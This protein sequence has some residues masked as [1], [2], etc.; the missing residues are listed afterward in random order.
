MVEI[1][2]ENAYSDGHESARTTKVAEPASLSELD[3]EDWWQD[4]VFPQTGDG[5]GRRRGRSGGAYHQVTVI[6]ADTTALIGQTHE[7]GD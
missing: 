4:V 7:W 5:H 1:R 2:I 6:K 3:L